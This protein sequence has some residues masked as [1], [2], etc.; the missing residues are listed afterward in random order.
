[1]TETA[2]PVTGQ[3]VSV[4]RGVGPAKKEA[5]SKLGIE[6]VGDAVRCWPRAYQNRGDTKT[7]AEIA[8]RCRAGET[9]P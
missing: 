7:L 8:A 2:G 5:L 6:T 4:L 3:D 9:G 1:M